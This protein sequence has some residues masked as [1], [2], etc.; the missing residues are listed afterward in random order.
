MTLSL[1]R[2]LNK[3]SCKRIVLKKSMTLRGQMIS[4]KR[5]SQQNRHTKSPRK[6]RRRKILRRAQRVLR[7]NK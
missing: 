7:G 5:A 3:N 6:D 1:K 2:E 4:V